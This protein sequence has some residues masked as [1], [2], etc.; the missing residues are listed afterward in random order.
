MRGRP[1]SM[2]GLPRSRTQV[3][4]P[5]RAGASPLVERAIMEATR[6]KEIP[7]VLREAARVGAG[8]REAAVA[9]LTGRA[10]VDSWVWATLPPERTPVVGGPQRCWRAWEEIGASP[11]WVSILREGLWAPVDSGYD[12]SAVPWGGSLAK[13]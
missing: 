9:V 11:M 8:Q 12:I 1:I 2:W 3:E 6:D 10:T 5:E 13:S 7:R 4:V